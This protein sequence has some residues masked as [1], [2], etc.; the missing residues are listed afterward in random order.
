MKMRIGGNSWPASIFKVLLVAV[1]PMHVWTY[2]ILMM[3]V[4]GK[5]HVFSMAAIAEG[6]INQGHE[7]TFFAAESFAL[8]LPELRNRTGFSV[9]TYKDTT[10]YEAA[11]ENVT[12]LL[13]ESGSYNVW[14]LASSIS[15][16]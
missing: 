10:N 13:V 1:L 2:K 8:N 14:Q 15:D 11:D 4:V 7:V 12:R 3:P 6:L 5:S 9:V 16:M